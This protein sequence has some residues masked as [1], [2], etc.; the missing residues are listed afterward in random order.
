MKLQTLENFNCVNH[1][2]REGVGICMS[3]NC[4]KVVCDEC[5]TKLEG[6]NTCLACLNARVKK[7]KPKSNRAGKILN[8]LVGTITTIAGFALLLAILFGLGKWIPSTSETRLGN[9]IFHN[10]AILEAM[11]ESFQSFK[12]DVGHYPGQ[13]LGFDALDWPAE[14]GPEPQGYSGSYW[15]G[16]WE[17]EITVRDGEP[18]DAYRQPLRYYESKQL[19]CPVIVSGGPDGVI[20]TELQDLIDIYL[21][22]N[23]TARLVGSGDDQIAIPR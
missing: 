13:K 14:W 2:N 5:S 12:R 17:I 8:S 1:P 3:R 20:E 11:A 16:E 22:A 21:K 4:R 9:R 19:P 23:N 15:P 6:I 7:T 18:L 10:K